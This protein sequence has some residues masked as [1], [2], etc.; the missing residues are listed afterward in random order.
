M[1]L[2][3]KTNGQPQHNQRLDKYISSSYD[4]ERMHNLHRMKS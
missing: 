3:I 2:K 1:V 4:L